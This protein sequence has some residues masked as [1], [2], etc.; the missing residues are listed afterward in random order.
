MLVYVTKE[1]WLKWVFCIPRE[2]RRS[3]GKH[4]E[5]RSQQQLIVALFLPLFT[6]LYPIFPKESFRYI[7]RQGILTW[8]WK[9]KYDLCI[10]YVLTL[11]KHCCCWY[12]KKTPWLEPFKT[13]ILEIF[14]KQTT[15]WGEYPKKIKYKFKT[16]MFPRHKKCKIFFLLGQIVQCCA[17]GLRQVRYWVY[18]VRCVTKDNK[19]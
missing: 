9:Y 13:T 2:Y 15:Y 3:R 18:K 14:K 4:E 8:F 19:N 5:T 12:D 6:W 7:L 1:R 17:S 10:S 16:E 11:S